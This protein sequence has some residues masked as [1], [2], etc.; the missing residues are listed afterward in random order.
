[1]RVVLFEMNRGK[2]RFQVFEHALIRLH[3]ICKFL[4]FHSA[5]FNFHHLQSM[6]SLRA[7]QLVILIG[8]AST[9]IRKMT[10][11]FLNMNHNKGNYFF[12]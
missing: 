7:L 11:L 4:I 9:L 1:M 12:T 2:D 5:V 3:L 8:F 10:S 6:I